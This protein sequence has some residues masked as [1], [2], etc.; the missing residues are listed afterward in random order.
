MF[1]NYYCDY[2]APELK[3]PGAEPWLIQHWRCP[4]LPM[5]CGNSELSYSLYRSACTD[6]SP[7]NFRR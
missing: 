1:K 5:T 6:I 7:R 4:L 2:E 3:G